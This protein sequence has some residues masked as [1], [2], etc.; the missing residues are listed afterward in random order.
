MRFMVDECTGPTVATWLRLQ[1][2]DVV[3]IFDDAR[4][5]DDD[6]VLERAFSEQR[7]LIT[8][9]KDFGEMVFREKRCHH[10]IV[11]LRLGNPSASRHIQAL[12]DLLKAHASALADHF[13]VVADAG[14]RIV[15]P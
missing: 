5:A 2:H 4:G 6:A 7:I 10:G 14:V 13:V 1:G 9:D 11:L 12:D 15:K 8:S 3:S